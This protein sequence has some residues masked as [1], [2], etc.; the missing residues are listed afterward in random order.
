MECRETGLERR[1]GPTVRR[2]IQD[3]AHE[4]LLQYPKIPLGMMPEHHDHVPEA[5]MSQG[6]ELMLE[7]GPAIDVD[8]ALGHSRPRGSSGCKDDD[9]MTFHQSLP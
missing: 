1:K 3:M 6:I 7:P 5:M 8:Q 9:R 2:W 4:A